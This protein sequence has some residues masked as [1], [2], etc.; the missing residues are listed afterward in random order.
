[1]LW[2]I[3]K[4]AEPQTTNKNRAIKAG[5]TGD[6]SSVFFNVFGTIPLA[7][8]FLLCLSLAILILCLLAMMCYYYISAKKE[9]RKLMPT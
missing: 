6:F 5:P 2:M 4:T 7:L 1:M 3:W 9:L 8:I